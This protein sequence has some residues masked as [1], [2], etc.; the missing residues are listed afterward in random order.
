MSRSA[1]PF[2]L[3]DLP[4]LGSRAVSLLVA[5]GIKTPQG[6][7][8]IGAV[9]AA[10]RIGKLRPADP[11]RRKMLVILQ[12]AIRGVGWRSISDDEREELWKRYQRRAAA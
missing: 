7:R 12:G 3:I 5:A 8:R 11:P 2:E 9:G 4:N 6:L 10:L 1:P